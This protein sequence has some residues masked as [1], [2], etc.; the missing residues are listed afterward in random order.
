MLTQKKYKQETQRQSKCKY[1]TN[2]KEK[3]HV[4]ARKLAR[5]NKKDRHKHQTTGP[6]DLKSSETEMETL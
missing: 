5:A 1:E 3:N 6:T 2:Q 4:K